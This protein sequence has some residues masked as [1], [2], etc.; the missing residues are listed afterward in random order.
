MTFVTTDDFNNIA[1]AIS[2]Y[3][4]AERADAALILSSG[5][6]TS[7]SRVT[8]AGEGFTGTLRWLRYT[9][10]S[11]ANKPVVDDNYN[12]TASGQTLQG[13][14]YM[15]VNNQAEVYVKN[16]DVSA[17]RENSVQSLISRVDGLS[18]LGRQ[19]GAVRARREDANLRAVLRGITRQ[20]YEAGTTPIANDTPA[21]IH[22]QF[23]YNTALTGAVFAPLFD[24]TSATDAAAARSDFF[25][26]LLDAMTAVSGEFEEPFYYLAVS[27]ATFNILRKENVLDGNLVQDGN[28][29]FNTVLGGK[30]RLI[31]TGNALASDTGISPAA[32]DLQT[33]AQA[34]ILIKPGY[35]HYS[36][37]AINNP[38]AMDVNPLNN[39]GFGDVS[40]V[41]RWGNI[42]HPRG[43]SYSN[44]GSAVTAFPTNANLSDETNW[45][46]S[47][48]NVNQTGIFPI[49]HG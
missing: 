24:N 15:T 7:D 35:I 14:N 19:F 49:F 13:A 48:Q 42:I 1:Q 28:I 29:D 36:N 32:S 18:Y 30:I 37:V 17:A 5:I 2:V 38:T 45:A 20:V 43:Y 27:P 3:A 41:N 47:A 4:D 26:T 46:R 8:D 10:G 33:G 16:V 11:D 40:I 31:V 6:V 44:A 21:G 23:G 9:D 39:N 22:G 34:S 25:D 12:P